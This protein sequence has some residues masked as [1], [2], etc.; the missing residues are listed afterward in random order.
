[1]STANRID[2]IVIVLYALLMVRVGLAA[3]RSFRP[4]EFLKLEF[5]C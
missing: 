4:K 3:S 5:V 1:M 2:Y